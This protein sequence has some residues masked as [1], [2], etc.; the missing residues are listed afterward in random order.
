[1]L[2]CAPKTST[3]LVGLPVH[4]DPIN[5][6]KAANLQILER[7]REGVPKKAGYRINAEKVANHRLKVRGGR[8]RGGEGRWRWGER[9]RERERESGAKL[10]S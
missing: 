1:M 10:F 5:A 6:L 4:K 3:G 8:A 9:G 2:R 7:L